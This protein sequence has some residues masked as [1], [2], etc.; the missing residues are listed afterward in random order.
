MGI[1]IFGMSPFNKAT[2]TAAEKE[3]L[4]NL[5]N[6]KKTVN[7]QCKETMKDV[8]K[9]ISDQKINVDQFRLLADEFKKTT[10]IK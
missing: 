4:K 1:K 2:T 10:K 8:N 3:A 6:A 9:I 5:Q 7:K